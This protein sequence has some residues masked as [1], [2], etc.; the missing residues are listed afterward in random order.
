MIILTINKVIIN[1]K[2][3]PVLQWYWPPEIYTNCLNSLCFFFMFSCIN[4]KWRIYWK[5]IEI[6]QWQG[7]N[8]T[9]LKDIRAVIGYGT[10][11]NSVKYIEQINW[12]CFKITQFSFCT[13]D[14][15]FLVF[16]RSFFIRLFV[17]FFL[18][19]N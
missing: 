8:I 17:A 11:W 14:L 1:N 4:W 7:A 5:F 6:I 18:V 19:L 16:W 15:T 10:G 13:T 3:T 9:S 2:Y 12:K